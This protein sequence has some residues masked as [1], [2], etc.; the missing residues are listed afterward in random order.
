M[1][2]SYRHESPSAVVRHARA[3][4][5][6]RV[7]RAQRRALRSDLADR[8]QLARWF[9]VVETDA[10]GWR[11]Y[12]WFLA[13][14]AG[15]IAAARRAVGLLLEGDSLDAEVDVHVGRV[16]PD[17]NLPDGYWSEEPGGGFEEYPLAA[18]AGLERLAALRGD[19]VVVALPG[20]PPIPPADWADVVEA[21][22]AAAGF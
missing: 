18:A 2:H 12:R 7:A 15:P 13:V 19:G 22:E 3:I 1:S 14:G 5:R 10:D 16:A 21:A 20:E 8:G 11:D 4:E 6:N 9:Q 17:V